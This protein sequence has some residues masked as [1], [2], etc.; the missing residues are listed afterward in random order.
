MTLDAPDAKFFATVWDYD[1]G[2]FWYDK[3]SHVGAFYDK[4][5]ALISLTDPETHF[6]GDNLQQEVDLAHRH[7]QQSLEGA[8]VRSR[9]VVTGSPGTSR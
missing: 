2:Y 9:S 4:F 1:T 7:R 3:V 6:L 8:A 5:M